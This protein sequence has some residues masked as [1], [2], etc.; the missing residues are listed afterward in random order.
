M[1]QSAPPF[2]CFAAS[3]F[4]LALSGITPAVGMID[5]SSATA[6]R[7]TTTPTEAGLGSQFEFPTAEVN[8]TT[9][10]YVRGGSG[11]AIILL[12]GYPQDWSE[13]RHVMPSLAG[14]FT[15]VVVDL[16]GVGGSKPTAGGYDAANLAAN[17]RAVAQ[18]LK[19]ERPYVAGHDIGGMAAYAYARAFPDDTSGVMVLD[20]PLPGIAFWP[21]IEREAT[22]IRDTVHRLGGNPKLFS[23]ADVARFA[24]AYG[25]PCSL[26]AGFEFADEQP[27]QVA[28]L[29]AKY[30]SR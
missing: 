10:H 1:K 16:R 21:T 26:R 24:V 12:H 19:L 6:G 22:Y 30:A 27:D 9:L 3:V 4:A 15:V 7:G 2:F 5:C 25:T 17:T 29:I 23:K 28:R 8:G 14:Q 18:Q 11:P 13:W 20:V